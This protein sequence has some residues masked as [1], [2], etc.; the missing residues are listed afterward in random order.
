M[1]NNNLTVKPTIT[2][3]ISHSAPEKN[4]AS[5]DASGNESFQT[6]LKS[7]SSREAKDN[8]SLKQTGKN[9]TQSQAH[10]TD[11]KSVDAEH[12]QTSTEPEVQNAD[13]KLK[14]AVAEN[15]QTT[16]DPKVLITETTEATDSLQVQT[17]ATTEDVLPLNLATDPAPLSLVNIL[18]AQSFNEKLQQQSV[19]GSVNETTIP[20]ATV[21]TASTET[22]LKPQNTLIQSPTLLQA[23]TPAAQDS[24]PLLADGFKRALAETVTE[25]FGGDKNPIVPKDHAADTANLNVSA[26]VSQEPAIK[27]ASSLQPS[28]TH[29]LNSHFYSDNWGNDLNQQVVSL[30]HNNIDNATLRLNP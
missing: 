28:V 27:N 18:A 8:H 6:T 3:L 1:S 9:K 7:Y 30:R 4:P 16:V 22:A 24:E 14:L 10:A 25:Q 20:G 26:L 11:K 5:K 2:S 17:P 13:S 23:Q 21:P 15:V 19:P 12:A 29:T